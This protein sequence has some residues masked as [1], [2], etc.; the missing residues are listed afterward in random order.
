MALLMQLSAHLKQ[1]VQATALMTTGR[2][3]LISMMSSG[4]TMAH[5]P[6]FSQTSKSIVI[7]MS[8]LR[9]TVRLKPRALMEPIQAA[10]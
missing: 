3:F 9:E 7:G 4:H 5:T 8:V 2:L 6:V 10:V 1:D